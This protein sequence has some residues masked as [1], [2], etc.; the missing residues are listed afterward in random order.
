MQ[1]LDIQ[2]IYTLLK[3]EWVIEFNELSRTTDVQNSGES[4]QK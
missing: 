2:V 4:S 3:S 1:I